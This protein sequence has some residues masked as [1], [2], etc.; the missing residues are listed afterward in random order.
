M[1]IAEARA[2]LKIDPSMTKAA[3]FLAY[4]CRKNDDGIGTR[5]AYEVAVAASPTAVKAH[6]G[7]A[8]TCLK[9][10]D[11]IAALQA[12]KT[13]IALDNGNQ[14]AKA[15]R[16]RI[17]VRRR[18]IVRAFLAEGQIPQALAMAGQIIE[19]FGQTPENSIVL[20]NCLA[21]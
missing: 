19:D 9:L 3:Y 2:V 7:L 8:A 10:G 16:G 14:S 1:A 17:L 4:H 15:I 6:L 11:D 12:C 20:A 13:V 21:R 18:R 5:Q